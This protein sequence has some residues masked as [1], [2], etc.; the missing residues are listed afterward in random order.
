MRAALIV[1]FVYAIAVRHL[2]ACLHRRAESG[3]QL[4]ELRQWAARRG[5]QVAAE[6]VFDGASAWKGEYREQLAA[7]LT[8]ARLGKYDVLLVWAI[9]RIDREGVESTLGV[10][11]RFHEA[12]APVWSLKEPWTETADP[13]LAERLAA[14]YAWMAA[15]ESRRR[16]ER[17]KAGL[18]RRKA[19]GKPPV[20][21]RAGSYRKPRR[22]SGYYVRWERER[23]AAS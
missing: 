2:G 5:L 7:A 12:G 22:R 20:G 9:D 17:V 4:P 1:G 18:T 6:Y 15:K 11:R 21:R 16:S 8:G 19:E 14:I 13:R 3:N 10:L 23:T